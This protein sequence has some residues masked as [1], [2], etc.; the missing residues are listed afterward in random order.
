MNV[1]TKRFDCITES[2]FG[3]LGD[4][5]KWACGE[6]V[7]SRCI[8]I[9]IHSY[10]CH[11]K[12]GS[13]PNVFNTSSIFRYEDISTSLNVFFQFVLI[14]Y[15]R[16]SQNLL[17]EWS[18]TALCQKFW[19]CPIKHEMKVAEINANIHFHFKSID[20]LLVSDDIFK[21]FTIK[22]QMGKDWEGNSFNQMTTM[23][24][25]TCSSPAPTGIFWIKDN[26]NMDLTFFF[27]FYF[28]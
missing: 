16:T 23:F 20:A 17:S 11:R 8:Q 10:L 24:L 18:S 22:W 1:S 12:W 3:G 26:M 4:C 19:G 5:E 13:L 25:Y 28:S 15:F 7:Q 6:E 21:D 9:K 14:M 2:Q 27:F